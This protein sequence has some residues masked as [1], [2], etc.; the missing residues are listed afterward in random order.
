M[1]FWKKRSLNGFC[2]AIST[3]TVLVVELLSS[4]LTGTADERCVA[5]DDI[6][7]LHRPVHDEAV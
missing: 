4:L 1:L 5:V 3:S 2:F 7:Q 6:N